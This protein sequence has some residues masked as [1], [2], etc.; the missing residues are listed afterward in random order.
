MAVAAIVIAVGFVAWMGTHQILARYWA[1]KGAGAVAVRQLDRAEA[2]FQ[3]AVSYDPNLGAGKIGLARV[4]RL[5][6]Q[7]NRAREILQQLAS[8][9]IASE[10][11]NRELLLVQI[12][13]GRARELYGNFSRLISQRP[14]DVDAVWQA[15]V[16]GFEFSGEAELARELA[17]NWL[18]ESPDSPLAH[19]SMA[20]LAMERDEFEP[21][22]RH[23]ALAAQLQPQLITAWQGLMRVSTINYQHRDALL[24]SEQVLAL[25]PQNIEAQV[26]KADCLLVLH[27]DQEAMREF[28][29]ALES[30]SNNFSVRYELASLLLKHDQAD[31]ALEVMKP[32]TAEFSDDVAIN[33]LMAVAHQQLGNDE[34]AE[35]YLQKHLDGR[36]ALN[37]LTEMKFRTEPGDRDFSFCKTVGLAY[38]RYQWDAAFPWLDQAVRI[39]PMDPEVQ[40]ALGDFAH[41]RGDGELAN[42]YHRQADLVRQML[43][44][45]HAGPGL[46]PPR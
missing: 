26:R 38:L 11:T 1:A 8:A 19:L 4:A 35:P 44:R 14:D 27:R 21:A 41:K 30:H 43:R 17:S 23:F 9:G 39:N 45:G 15:F 12:H 13:E 5:R 32:L 28:E 7:F 31:R 40:Q 16:D 42:R 18:K 20:Q 24:Y 29:G 10:G 22:E 3:K 2:D 36:Q 25:D 46:P 37:R 6:G 34:A 33:Y